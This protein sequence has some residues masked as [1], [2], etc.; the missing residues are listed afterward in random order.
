MVDIIIKDWARQQL[1]LADDRYE[2]DETWC[3]YALNYAECSRNTTQ[4]QWFV[5]DMLH[6]KDIPCIDRLK[7]KLKKNDTM[8]YAPC[9]S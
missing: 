3:F 6:S 1:F 9:Y 5:N 7:E 2:K 4:G 8:P